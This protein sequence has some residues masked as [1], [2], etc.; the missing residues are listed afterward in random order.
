MQEV[1]EIIKFLNELNANN[2]TNYKIKVLENYKT[3]D[4]IKQFLKF[5]YDTI[6]YIY[7]IR[8]TNISLNSSQNSQT[9]AENSLKSDNLPRYFKFKDLEPLYSNQISGNKAIQYVQNLFDTYTLN[10]KIILQKILERD[11]R[12]GINKKSI[13]KVF[14]NLIFELPYM[15]CSLID[16]IENISYPAIL[17]EKM[18]GTFRTIIKNNSEIIA[19]SRSGEPYKYENLFKEFKDLPNGAYIGELLV[20]NYE[21]RQQSN[22][23]LNSLSV[24]DVDFYIW[25][26]LDL[27]SFKKGKSNIKYIERFKLLTT[28]LNSSDMPNTCDNSLKSEN[29]QN[30]CQTLQSIKIVKSE[31]VSN[32][33]E[34]I[35][36]TRKWIS[37]GKEGSV[38]KD[39]KTIFEN[40]TSKYQIKLKPEFD[41]DVKIV[42]YTDGTGKYKDYI[43]A[44]IFESSDG[45][46]QGQCS[47]FDENTRFEIS[48][49]KDFYINKIFSMTGTAI[50]RAKDS[51]T[52]AIMHPRFKALRDD[53]LEA[54][55]YKR[56]LEISNG[57]NI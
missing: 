51:T 34:A 27:E 23:L 55:T 25:D 43:G 33:Y 30:T 7:N 11:L 21:N 12:A 18:D 36:I 20:K 56:I 35:D 8:L 39:F 49:N 42:G 15:R 54:D 16:K 45:L 3:C 44:L 29:L 26:Y 2:S 40:K 17:Q 28:L 57:F 41:I 52:Y 38:L 47:G 31:I 50:T 14:K 32:K 4:T 6:T 46:V 37:E 53:K 1:Q 24:P 19:F 9:L 5:V 22:G 10:S 48:K 13:N